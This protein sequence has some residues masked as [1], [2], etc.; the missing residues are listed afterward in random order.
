[1]SNL[2]HFASGYELEIIWR[3]FVEGNIDKNPGIREDV[4]DS[5]MR[6]KKWGISPYMEMAPLVLQGEKLSV[7]LEHKRELL[8]VAF[9]VVKDIYS[10]VK[11]SNSSVWVCNEKGILLKGVSDPDA[12]EFCLTDNLIEGADWS[13]NRVGTNAIGSALYLKRPIQFNEAEHYRLKAHKGYCSAAPIIGPNGEILGVL[14][15]TGF[16]NDFNR[17]TLGMV[18]A[19]VEAI[20]RELKLKALYQKLSVSHQYI[21]EMIESLPSGI[22]V[23]NRE[24]IITNVN[25]QACR[26]L[27][28]SPPELV[29]RSI[30]DELKP[31]D[32]L[33]KTL[34]SGIEMEETEFFQEL[35]KKKTHFTLHSRAIKTP[36]GDVDGAVII[37]REFETVR[38]IAGKIAGYTAKFTFND[39]IGE[40]PSFKRMLSMAI[41]A[42]ST[43]TNMLILGESGTGKEIVAQAIHN[44]S[45]RA[46]GPFVAVNCGAL[47]RE[48]VGSE[49]FGYEEGA[50]TGAKKGGSPGKFELANNGTLFLD[51]IGDMSLDLQLVLLRVLQEK[52]LVR[53]GGQKEI[54][55][56]V[57]VIA[58]TNKNISQMVDQGLFR[59]DLYYR[60][61]V[62]TLQLP[63][64]RQRKSDISLLVNHIVKYI[65]DKTG[66]NS[67]TISAQTI[68][69]LE[70]Y[71][72][73]GNV[74]ELE[75]VLERAILFSDDSVLQIGPLS[76]LNSGDNIF[77]ETQKM[78]VKL[79][80]SDDEKDLI[81]EVLAK[82][83]GNISKTSKELGIT[84]ATLYKK[85]QKYDIQKINPYQ[86]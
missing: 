2:K 86:V 35:G 50:F 13:E 65:C 7:E 55:I 83:N 51:E 16:S 61:N 3:E 52:V 60:L 12:Y 76:S 54:P 62:I 67:L 41:T 10:A 40:E 77:N 79:S 1:M 45:S 21:M 19:G 5:W 32:C 43:S 38:K 26:M 11:G 84:R 23:V 72:W 8:S 9:E 53:L 36:L 4:F 44:A 75:N 47:P 48:L 33:K 78:S 22:V 46:F 82:C 49:L 63:P 59:L 31:I 85:I 37:L 20:K 68:A 73:P 74:R 58:A 80:H 81:I 17:H 18:V 29:N 39:I 66:K 42:A 6:S 70:K 71:S 15:V 14:D 69:E 28:A 30:F 25:G 24:G 56:N 57:R 27:M 34:N 64:L